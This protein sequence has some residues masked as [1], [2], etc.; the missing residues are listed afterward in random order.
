M[1]RGLDLGILCVADVL[2]PQHML[3]DRQPRVSIPADRVGWRKV[4]AIEEQEPGI[5][6]SFSIASVWGLISGHGR[7]RQQP[8]RRA[9]PPYNRD[10]DGVLKRLSPAVI[11][12]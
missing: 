1:P 3:V 9:D 4:L 2:R 5:L 12:R 10:P 7:R 8:Q 6:Q 11:P